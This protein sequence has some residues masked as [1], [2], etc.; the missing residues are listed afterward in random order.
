MNFVYITK[1]RRSQIANSTEVS[2]SYN[3][4]NGKNNPSDFR[5][6]FSESIKSK[7]LR[8]IEYLVVAYDSDCPD[9]IWF[10]EDTEEHGFKL[11]R[12]NGKGRYVFTPSGLANIVDIPTSFVGDYELLF[13]PIIKM[14]YIDR[15]EK[16]K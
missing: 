10:K 2:V 7:V 9:R 4:T 1:A 13:D 12:G 11:Y 14:W 6:S 3:K 5:F 16:I 15:N 8:N